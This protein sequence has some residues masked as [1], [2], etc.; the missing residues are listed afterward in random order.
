V[1]W[2]NELGAYQQFFPDTPALAGDFAFRGPRGDFGY[3]LAYFAQATPTDLDVYP[4]EPI[5]FSGLGG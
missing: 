1:N 3:R 2:F 5:D 4:S